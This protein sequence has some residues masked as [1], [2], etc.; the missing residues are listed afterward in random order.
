MARSSPNASIMSHDQRRAT[1]S[2]SDVP[3]ASDTSVAY[4]PVS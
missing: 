2:N 1:T 3:E 4:S